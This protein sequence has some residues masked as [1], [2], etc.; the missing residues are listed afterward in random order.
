MFDVLFGNENGTVTV[1]YARAWT[2]IGLA[3]GALGSFLYTKKKYTGEL[4]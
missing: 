3:T 2:L 4:F 1:N